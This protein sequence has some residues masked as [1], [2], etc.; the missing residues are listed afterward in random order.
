[1]SATAIAEPIARKSAAGHIDF[2]NA[3]IPRTRPAHPETLTDAERARLWAES[4]DDDDFTDKA[5]AF[6]KLTGDFT[7]DRH[8]LP[9]PTIDEIWEGI[10]RI[11]AAHPEIYGTNPDKLAGGVTKMTMDT[12]TVTINTD[13]TNAPA[14]RY[15]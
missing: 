14:G 1:M 8:I 11:Q 7:I 10:D 3:G 6:G 4:K 13:A 12:A 15:A 5:I 2:A 9:E